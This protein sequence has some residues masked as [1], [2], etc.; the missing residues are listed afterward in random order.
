M[1]E[2]RITTKMDAYTG[3]VG[4]YYVA[5]G[6]MKRNTVITDKKKYMYLINMVSG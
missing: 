2:K 1:T 6:K 3:W 4:N 5:D